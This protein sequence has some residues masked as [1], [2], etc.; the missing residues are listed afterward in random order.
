MQFCS[1][2]TLKLSIELENMNFFQKKLFLT[3]FLL[4]VIAL[5]FWTGS[6]YPQLD[7]KAMMGAN[8]PT[9]GISFDVVKQVESNQSSVEK[10][11]YNTLNWIDTNKKGMTFGFLFGSAFI[12]LFS[13]LKD[14]TLNNRF[15]NTA[16][17]AIIGAPLG[18]CVN[19]AAPIAKGM[20]DAGAKTETALA[21]M[22]ASP[23]LN[24][25]VLS[26]LFSLLPAYMGWLKIGFT[27]LFI[28]GVIPLASSL[29]K[30]KVRVLVAAKPKK[31]PVFNLE[32]DHSDKLLPSSWLKA[33]TWT[34]KSYLK[35]LWFIVK[36][37][38]PLMI[39]AGLLG[40]VLIT[41]LPLEELIGFVKNIS[42]FE[43]LIYML[44]IAI[45]ATFLPVPIAFD[46]IIVAILWSTGLHSRFAMVLLFCLGTFSIYSSFIVA[47]SFSFKLSILLFFTT[48][49]FGF[50]AG[51]SG[52]FLERE[53][54]RNHR[55]KNYEQF[56]MTDSM[57]NI[58]E[59]N[60]SET[61]GSSYSQLKSMISSIELEKRIYK[62]DSLEIF[63]T[64]FHS[65][66]RKLNSGFSKIEGNK[67]GLGVPYHFSAKETLEPFANH[68]S[69]ASGDVQQDGYAD[70]LIVSS[71]DLY[72]YA[73]I[74][75]KEFKRQFLPSFQ[76]KSVYN[77]ALVDFDNDGWKDIFFS[78]YGNGNYILKNDTG[79]FSK[80]DL[81]KLPQHNE[82]ILTVAPA[83][84]DID[85]DGLID[86]VLGN[87]SVGVAAIDYSMLSSKNFC[88]INQGAFNFELKKL[89]G[90][91]G[92][93]LS[94]LVS[95]IN[96]DGKSDLIV[97]NDFNVPDHYYLSSENNNTI[98]WVRKAN[99]LVEKSTS[100]TM[101]V[102]S[103]DV[104]NDL[105]SEVF[106]AQV[107]RMQGTKITDNV[108]TICAAIEDKD[109]R[110]NCEK[111]LEMQQAI[112]HSKATRNFDV[113]PEEYIN[114]CIGVELLRAKARDYVVEIENICNVFPK[115]WE[116]YQYFCESIDKRKTPF[117]SIKDPAYEHKMQ[118]GL[119]LMKDS[120][121][122][123][124]DQTEKY[125]LKRTGWAW[126]SKF[127]D[128]DNDSWQ[129]LFVVN[130]YLFQSAQESHIFYKNI[131]GE[132]FEDKTEELGLINYIPTSSYSYLDFDSD[133]DMDIIVTPA[134]GPVFIYKNNFHKNNSLAFSIDDGL[135]NR[136]GVG[137]VITIFYGKD[138]HQ[139]R[140]IVLSGGYKSFDETVAYFG[141][142]KYDKI[143]QLTINWSTGEETIVK[144][145]L[146]A[147]FTYCINR[148]GN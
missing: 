56:K 73:N 128:I 80:K 108:S 39:L 69:I 117:P 20:K 74:N 82:M 102:T 24:I 132:T 109:E 143:N 125:K 91:D 47:K 57:P 148:K 66:N 76:S 52:H 137:T 105:I 99:L 119:L 122:F 26:M 35:S 5:I 51:I 71:E 70:L 112:N 72:L 9:M 37:T 22:I 4:A 129:D 58:L 3:I 78:T 89:D 115:G 147:G 12:L 2:K 85:E 136:S 17:G 120:T 93:T 27:L 8:S 146:L 21:T 134:I 53:L 121:G 77:A 23:T 90:I 92:E 104:N 83:F 7:S 46:V 110:K 40:N 15:L 88:L 98:N 48:V 101:S 113:C 38:L 59:F 95:D 61:K 63:S 96:G 126:N 42:L 13:L 131:K 29:F 30:E 140:E 49:A 116:Q 19:C 107:G 145:E 62:T 43:K 127:C 1:C 123:F 55:L 130:G 138:K 34:G 41:F 75:G 6:R 133:G 141:L 28:F 144:K 124:K 45:F 60:V 84:A 106:Q 97:G 11:A 103:V 67:I 33:L 87:W 65:K 18:V 14:V 10:I 135:G 114:D 94:T 64:P 68:R 50:A 36:T 44:G 86:I 54:G 100:T 118:G 79:S 31:V 81:I 32:N 16:F 142:G 139:K 25:I 111:I